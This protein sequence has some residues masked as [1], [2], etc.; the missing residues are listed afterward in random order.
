MAY[1]NNDGRLRGR[2]L[3]ATRL[4]IWSNDPHCARC[5]KLV[6]YPDGFEL[7]HIKALHKE[8]STNDDDNLQ[9]LCVEVKDGVKIGCHIDKTA[10]DLGY[11]K[12]A[13]FDADGRCRASADRRNRSCWGRRGASIRGI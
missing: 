13:E 12:Q 7:D 6:A 5:R 1:D 4:R 2:K 11:A 10:D 8:G 3:Q 9:V